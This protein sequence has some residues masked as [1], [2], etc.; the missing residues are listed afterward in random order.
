LFPDA[1]PGRILAASG[2]NP[3]SILQY[4]TA[5]GSNPGSF[6]QHA[7]NCRYGCQVLPELMPGAATLFCST[8]QQFWQHL[9]A[10]LP[11][12]LAA[13]SG[14]SG[15]TWQ[16]VWQQLLQH[17]T[18]LLSATGS[19]SNSSWQPWQQLGNAAR[20][21]QVMPEL[22]HLAAILAAPGS[23]SGSTW[24]QFWQHL[25][26]F[27]LQQAVLA[28]IQGGCLVPPG[29]ARMAARISARTAGR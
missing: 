19:S 3:W 22:W 28:A 14:Q 26:G 8:L 4:L 2:S 11:A 5:L 16:Q 18:S 10:R 15:Y 20:H 23:S 17:L 29:A 1:T 9:A 25:A 27:R 7:W 6:W 21:C 24:Q 12:S 13:P